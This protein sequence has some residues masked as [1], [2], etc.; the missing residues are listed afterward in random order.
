VGHRPGAK[1]I[2]STHKEASGAATRAGP[3]GRMGAL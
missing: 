2:L 3:D 1:R